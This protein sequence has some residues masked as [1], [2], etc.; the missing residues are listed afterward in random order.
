M[1]IQTLGGM[2]IYC[3]PLDTVPPNVDKSSEDELAP[4]T[5]DDN[6]QDAVRDKMDEI[7]GSIFFPKSSTDEQYSDDF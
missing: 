4:A 3:Y 5:D 7:Q 6:Y 1:I 2:Q